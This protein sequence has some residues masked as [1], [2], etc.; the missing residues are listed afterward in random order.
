MSFPLNLKK[1]AKLFGV[2]FQWFFLGIS[3]T[4]V[5]FKYEPDMYSIEFFSLYRVVQF[6]ASNLVRMDSLSAAQMDFGKH[7]DVMEHIQRLTRH[8]VDELLGEFGEYMKAQNYTYITE[9][10]N[11]SSGISDGN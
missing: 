5:N 2:F 1:L 8:G 11:H 4:I 9:N 3:K 7:L 10:R 6:E